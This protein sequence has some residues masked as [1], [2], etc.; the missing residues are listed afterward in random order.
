[1]DERR[2]LLAVV[3]I[4]L[5][6]FGYNAFMSRT[7]PAPEATPA[8]TEEQ[9]AA[10]GSGAA[11]AEP[12]TQEPAGD[13]A[14]GEH[15]AA[16][17]P[18]AGEI[19]GIA[20]TT[21]AE[22]ERTVVVES[23]LW[24]ATFS[25]RGAAV[26]SW[27]LKKYN[28]ASGSAVDLVPAGSRG[29]G[30]EVGY[31]P[32]SVATADWDFSYAGPE[33]VVLGG[34]G[35]D[36]ELVFEAARDGVAVSKRYTLSADG[37]AFRFALAVSGLTEPGARREVWIAWPGVLPS[38]AKED[39]N[40]SASVA[41]VDGKTV[42]TRLRSLK[43]GD[44]ERRTGAIDWVTS[45]SQYFV[46]AVVPDSG[47]FAAVEVFA[48]REAGTTGFRAAHQVE[49][50]ATDA[51]F[52]VYA[53]PQDYHALGSVGRHLDRA[54]DLGWAIFR[55]ISV[56]MLVA[57]VWAHR[58]IPNY[59]VVIII[60]SILTKLIFYR[61]THKSFTEMKRMQELQPKLA[62]LKEKFGSDREALAK[63]QMELYKKEGVNPMGSCLPMLLQMPVFIALYQVLRTTIELR[64]APFALWITDLSKPDT[65]AAIA[66]FPI[67][68]LPLLMGAAMLAQQRMSSK[69]PS[70]AIVNN[71]MPIVFTALFYSF[72]SGLV[73]YWLVNT[74]LSVAQQFIVQRG[75]PAARALG[76]IAPDGGPASSHPAPAADTTATD[77][78]VVDTV[79]GGASRAPRGGRRRGRR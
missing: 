11:P 9:P 20:E 2:A 69:D 54:I 33:R 74:V 52:L 50:D 47:S 71:L 3:L 8:G 78:V 21:T 13:A 37:Y 59:G 5:V 40:A 22:P 27:R 25:T 26:T 44:V 31:G 62:A 10:T 38:E 18:G 49:G 43:E 39:Q 73:I 56:F 6:L 34:E 32:T 75:T 72:A 76:A 64:G 67:H 66:G 19:P 28:G 55:P 29:L 65:V 58:F 70:Q 4:F 14:P 61:L 35:D 36:A 51:A 45:Q 24:V 12:A 68:I 60:F 57:L 77:A 53:G 17:A 15:A 30:V 16:P 7:A 42:R 1:M 41:L 48:D 46:T 63:A 23:P 79:K